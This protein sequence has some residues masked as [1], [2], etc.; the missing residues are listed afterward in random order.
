[1][2]RG[3]SRLLALLLVSVGLLSGSRARAG[4][5]PAYLPRYRVE[6]DL[7]VAGHRAAVSQTATWINP[8]SQPTDRLVF[9]VHS[10]YVVPADQVGFMAKMIEILR[11]QPS[12]A[13]GY[14]E[15]PCAV[16]H[17]SLIGPDGK[18]KNCTLHR[19]AIGGVPDVLDPSVDIAALLQAP[20]I[21]EY[22][23]TL[24]AFCVGCVHASTCGGGCGAAAEWVLGDARRFPDPLVWQHVD[25]DFASK[26]ARDRADGRRHL[27]VVV[28]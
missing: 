25:D 8:T 2:S 5:L 22:K 15:R 14:T 1:M 21:T 9:N 4:G 16:E 12:D 13:L 19:T 24:P 17:V 3:Y 7:D 11:V 18:L 6:V 28:S 23:K 26:L 10:R 20:E 27:E